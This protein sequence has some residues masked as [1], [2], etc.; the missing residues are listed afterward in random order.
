M[1]KVEFYKLSSRLNVAVKFAKAAVYGGV[2]SIIVGDKGGVAVYA[3]EKNVLMML[4]DDDLLT[5]IS[6]ESASRLSKLLKIPEGELKILDNGDLSVSSSRFD[7]K[8]PFD[9]A[10]FLFDS[11]PV[12][13]S[14]F[15]DSVNVL[16]LFSD[17]AVRANTFAASELARVLPFCG[18]KERGLD[19]LMMN[20]VEGENGKL[21]LESYGTDGS[22]IGRSTIPVEGDREKIGLKDET[23]DSVDVQ[24]ELKFDIPVPVASVLPSVAS[25]DGADRFEVFRSGDRV[26]FRFAE[27][28]AMTSQ[29]VPGI[30]AA[31]SGLG[32]LAKATSDSWS[33]IEVNGKQLLRAIDRASVVA[34]KQGDALKV[35]IEFAEDKIFVTSSSNIGEFSDAVECRG[36]VEPKKQSFNVKFLRDLI[37]LS[38]DDDVVLGVGGGK[39]S[40]L[41]LMDP[42]GERELDRRN[43]IGI[44]MPLADL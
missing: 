38:P 3:G 44:V 23:G 43:M 4:N 31:R 41:V 15:V 19:I 28:I 27:E 11:C 9:S 17:L 13:R 32:K 35:M 33:F 29:Y 20:V 30:P 26:V 1:S 24:D 14:S 39:M 25:L 2:T 5:S 37:S 21:F 22:R 40:A 6:T 16:G 36:K 34:S 42:L 12:D 10:S 7:A 18:G 8:V